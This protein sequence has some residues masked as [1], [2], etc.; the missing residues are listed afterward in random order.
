MLVK[1]SR[2][3]AEPAQH[4]ESTLR[5][6]KLKLL[7]P[8]NKDQHDDEPVLSGS[9]NF[10]SAK[11]AVRKSHNPIEEENNLMLI[12]SLPPSD[13]KPRKLATT[14]EI[15]ENI[16]EEQGKVLESS[17]AR[18]SK[19]DLEQLRWDDRNSESEEKKKSGSTNA[20]Q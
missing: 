8:S 9:K 3:L 20:V 17:R 6:Q 10:E 11:K 18:I 4:D 19:K 14:T 13:K 16:Q 12:T 2:D 15:A 5:K 7:K 1:R